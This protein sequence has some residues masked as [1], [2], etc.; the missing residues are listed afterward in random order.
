MSVIDGL[1]TV[2]EL[3]TAARRLASETL[4]TYWIEGTL[5]VDPVSL[6]RRMGIE[7]YRAQLGNDVFGMLVGTE[8]GA[9]MYLD[10]D[11]P[12]KRY[13]FTAAHEVGHYVDRA[14]DASMDVSFIDRRSESG[15]GTATEIFANEFA[16]SLLMPEGAFRA[17][18]ASGLDNFRLA[19]R[20]DVSL[21]AAAYRR[22]VLTT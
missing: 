5:P 15:R 19:E 7:V 20:F 16:G 10:S 3:R 4:D 14:V 6:A 2:R 18:V 1:S 17:A 11:Q 8:G 13:R 22:Q 9:A 12:E 21:G